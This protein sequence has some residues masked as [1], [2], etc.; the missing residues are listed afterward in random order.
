MK[1]GLRRMYLAFL[2]PVVIAFLIAYLYPVLR[3]VQMSFFE[4]SDISAAR[5]TWEFVGLYNYV[6]LFSRQLFRVSFKNMMLIFLAG[7]AA[8]FLISLF[9]AWVLHKGMFM[10]NLWRNLIYLPTVITPVAMITVWTQYAYNSRYGLLKTVF[11][12]LGLDGLAAIPWTSTQYAFWSML[13]AFCF[14]SIGGNLLVYMAAMKKIPDDLFEA[15]FMDGATEGKIFFRITLPLI[16]DNVKTQF[17]FWTIGC[18]GAE[19]EVDTQT[20]H[21]KV[22]KMVSCFDAGKVINPLTYTCQSEGAMVQSL[23][24]ALFEELKLKDG[25]VLNKSFVDYKIPTADDVPELVVKYVEHPEPTGP[26]GARGVGE[27]LMVPG[28]PAIANAVYQAIGVRFRRMP[29]TPDDVLKALRE[30]Q[31]TEKG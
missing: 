13:I 7:G 30:R 31:E 16:A 20:G 26:Y 24:T 12:T 22:L 27:P 17:T 11:E 5:D 28:A 23:G 29:I 19:V 1:K 2:S 18:N 25:K 9:F 8:V 3:T 21:I 4:V 10:G 14:C 6:D 15:A